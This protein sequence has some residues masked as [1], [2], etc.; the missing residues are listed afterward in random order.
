MAV[1][2]GSAAHSFAVPGPYPSH[3]Q[4]A[5]QKQDR[6]PLDNVVLQ[7]QELI[8]QLQ[9]KYKLLGL[10]TS[11]SVMVGVLWGVLKLVKLP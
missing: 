1:V 2:A 7:V 8:Q 6:G 4:L 10:A 11:P 9:G 5:C 3:A